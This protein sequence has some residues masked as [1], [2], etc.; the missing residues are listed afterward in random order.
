MTRFAIYARYSS[1]NQ[2]EKSVDDQVRECKARVRQMGGTVSETSVYADYAISGSHL[3]TRPGIKALMEHARAGAF[4]AVMSEDLSRLSRDQEDIAGVYKRLRFVG[5]KLFT[6]SEGEVNELHI[7]FK[8]TQNA[9]YLKDLSQKTKRGQRGRVEAGFIPGGKCY[10]Y[11][12]VR[13]LDDRGKVTTGL[14]KINPE[15]AEIVLRIFREYAAGKGTKS[16]ARD[17]NRDGVPGPTGREWAANA[18]TGN[19]ER[20]NGILNNEMYIGRIV[21][22]RQSFVKDPDTGKRQSRINPPEEWIIHEA[23]QYRIIPDDLWETVQLRKRATAKQSGSSRKRPPRLLSGLLKC[24]CCG[25][26][27]VITGGPTKKKGKNVGQ[28]RYGCSTRREKGTCDNTMTIGVLDIEDRLFEA[29]RQYLGH[30]KGLALYVREF[31]R[32]L[33]EQKAEINKEKSMLERKL[34]KTNQSIQSI[35]KAIEDGFYQSSMKDR[36]AELEEEKIRLEMEIK[37][38]DDESEVINF[39]PNIG[40]QYEKQLADLRSTIEGS[41]DRHQAVELLRSMIEEIRLI[42]NAEKGALD[43]AIKGNL[44][45]VL[46]FMQGDTDQIRY[47]LTRSM[48]EVVAGVGFEPTTF[49][50]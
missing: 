4:E 49:R 3:N 45:V 42:P 22:N 17:L 28:Y 7:G 10:G 24:G 21:H 2:N 47:H 31:H 1:E 12:V 36:L 16:I 5:V 44:A 13:E 41:E 8:G 15:H 48:S 9:M 39:L 43:L 32:H 29:L 11:D 27:Y 35:F 25:G 23:P 50:L 40:E 30:P 33:K 20:R 18:I 46:H 38:F 6:I 34:A 19:V 14:R 26:S 37:G